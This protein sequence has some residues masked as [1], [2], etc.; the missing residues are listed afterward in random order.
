MQTMGIVL[1][2][3]FGI[4]RDRFNQR[5]IFDV[6]YIYEDSVLSVL[7]KKRILAQRNA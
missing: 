5:V 4:E 2:L 6:M 7:D 1:R 3:G